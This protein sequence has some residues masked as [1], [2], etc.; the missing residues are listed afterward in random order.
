MQDVVQDLVALRARIDDLLVRLDVAGKRQRLAALEAESGQ[1]EFWADPE[2]AQRAMRQIAELRAEIGPWLDLRGRIAEQA[3]LLELALAEGDDALAAELAGQAPALGEELERLEFQLQLSGPYDRSNAILAVHARAGGTEAQD[4]GQMLMRMYLRWAERRGYK[5]EILDLSPGEEAGIKSVS[6]EIV[7]PYAYGY[8]K[9]ERGEHRL[10]RISPF[11]AQHRRHTSFALVEVMPEATEDLPLEI[12]PEEI[13]FEAFR[14]GGPGGQNVNKVNTA[15]RLTH[16]PTGIV[17]TCQTERSQ[18]Q[19][20]ETAMRM[21]KARLLEQEQERREAER[22]ALRGEHAE[23]SWGSQIRSYVLH[24][25]NLVKDLRTGY[26]TS[27]TTGVLDGELDG[28]MNAYLAWQVG[29]EPVMTE[30]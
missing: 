15:V 7:G 6:I 30:K 16:V 19:N 27:D 11:D 10:V 23:T 26:E 28:F 9:S 5:T 8:L 12:N 21:L 1:P 13:K 24:P 25:Y 22:A 3:E 14:S 20:R 29:R 4:W 2:A 17:V 18:L